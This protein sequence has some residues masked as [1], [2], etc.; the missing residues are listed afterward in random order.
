MQ[1]HTR[2][3]QK[4]QNMACEQS[5]TQAIS[6]AVIEAVKV[7]IIADRDMGIP[8]NTKWPVQAM[9]QTSGPVL[10]QPMFSWK[11]PD[12]C[13]ELWNFKIEVKNIFLINS[14]NIQEGQ[15]VPVI[16]NW[17]GCEGL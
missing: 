2:Q 16:M 12:V 7:V 3:S 1:T 15:K 9:P 4:K 14:Y 6:K 8:A 17:L 11:F 10:K 5:M 13:L